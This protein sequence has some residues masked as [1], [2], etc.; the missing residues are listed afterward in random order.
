MGEPS[1]FRKSVIDPEWRPQSAFSGEDV[2]AA[3]RSTF[4]ESVIDPTWQAQNGFSHQKKD[5]LEG[6]RSTWSKSVIDNTWV[7]QDGFKK[8]K[9]SW[10]AAG[11]SLGLSRVR[12]AQARTVTPTAP[13]EGVSL[14]SRESWYGGFTSGSAMPAVSF[15]FKLS[16]AE[17]ARSSA[18]RSCAETA[19]KAAPADV[20]MLDDPRY[21]GLPIDVYQARGESG[22]AVFTVVGG[23]CRPISGDL[24]DELGVRLSRSYAMDQGLGAY[25]E[26]L[27]QVR[28]GVRLIT[29]EDRIDYAMAVVSLIDPDVSGGREAAL[30]LLEDADVLVALAAEEPESCARSRSKR[31]KTTRK[32]TRKVARPEVIQ[33]EGRETVR[34]YT[35]SSAEGA[36]VRHDVR[37]AADGTVAIERHQVASHVGPHRDDD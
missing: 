14:A 33:G 10:D 31:K 32:A 18:L 15:R 7:P 1:K 34:L 25:D 20:R 9:T 29:A 13:S 35:W 17:R 26:V 4:R 28:A 12:L 36:V 21:S 37:L 6:S 30:V 22:R 5:V 19:L 8:K 16:S 23:T 27:G 24:R 11:R 3:S 2:L